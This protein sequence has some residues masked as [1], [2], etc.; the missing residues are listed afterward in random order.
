MLPWNSSKKSTWVKLW[1]AYTTRSQTTNSRYSSAHTK[2]EGL[3]CGSVEHYKTTPHKELLVSEIHNIIWFINS[4]KLHTRWLLQLEQVWH[5]RQQKSESLICDYLLQKPWP[6]FTSWW[7][8]SQM[9]SAISSF[10]RMMS[11]DEEVSSLRKNSDGS[12]AL[13]PSASNWAWKIKDKLQKLN[14]LF[15]TMQLPVFCICL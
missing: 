12:T 10:L 15:I 9:C 2:A 3:Q 1:L 6:F 11:R 14:F 4:S 7:I 13:C 8:T 5:L